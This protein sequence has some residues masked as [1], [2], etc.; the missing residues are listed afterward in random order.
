MNYPGAVAQPLR[1]RPLTAE[2]RIE[3]QAGLYGICGGQYITWASLL[4]VL[5]FNPVSIISPVLHNHSS[6]K[7]LNCLNQ[8]T[9]L[10]GKTSRKN[11]FL[12]SR[13]VLNNTLSI[14]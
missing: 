5:R 11:S 4:R 10:I 12:V 8:L 1:L 9:A 14:M 7:T 6:I 13:W 3:S 2:G